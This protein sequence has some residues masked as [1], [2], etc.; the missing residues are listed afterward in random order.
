MVISPPLNYTFVSTLK[1]GTNSLFTILVERFQGVRVGDFHCR[2]MRYAL[3]GSFTFTT[4]RN[5]YYRAVSI[6][7]STCMR[8]HDRYGFRR[9]CGNSSDFET[10]IAWVASL[11]A[12]PALLQN[13]TEWQEGIAFDCILHLENLAGE[14][15]SLP[16]VK[17]AV[18]ELPRIN[19]T[20]YNRLPAQHYLTPAA[21]ESIKLWAEPDFSNFDY[22][23][24]VP[25]LDGLDNPEAGQC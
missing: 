4:C 16:F 9:A 2:D 14:F 23:M 6:W 21:I 22:S 12:R 24:E 3:P 11:P 1:C 8:G 5:P 13:Q 17:E 15:S 25:S 18:A 20:L 19:T 10:F 7:W